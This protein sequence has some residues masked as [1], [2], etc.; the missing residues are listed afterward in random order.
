MMAMFT[1]GDS[2]FSFLMLLRAELFGKKISMADLIVLGGSAA[3]KKTAM[4]LDAS[5]R[6]DAGG[7]GIEAGRSPSDD[8]S[9]R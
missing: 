4:A 3:V 9:S 2:A 5:P 8:V 6:S 7:S 1:N